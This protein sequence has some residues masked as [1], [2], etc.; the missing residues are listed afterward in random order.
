[1]P[2]LVIWR[3]QHRLA[4]TLDRQSAEHA[5]RLGAET[6]VC[7]PPAPGHAPGAAEPS[8]LWAWLGLWGAAACA[9]VPQSGGGRRVPPSPATELVAQAA[10][11]GEPAFGPL[12]STAKGLLV[13]GAVLVAF[14]ATDW[15]HEVVAL[16]AA[17]VAAQPPVSFVRRDGLCRLGAAGDVHGPVCGQP[18][19]S[20]RLA[21]EAV[22]ALAAQGIH[23]GRR[24]PLFVAGP[25]PSN[26]P[27]CARRACCC[28]PMCRAGRSRAGL[29][30]GAGH[31]A[32]GGNLL[33]V[34]SI[35]NLIVADLPPDRYRHRLKTHARIGIPVTLLTLAVVA[36]WLR[37]CERSRGLK[38]SAQK[39]RT[40]DQASRP[41][42]GI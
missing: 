22:T 14:L 4:A 30:V 11:D 6:A 28:C 38:T 15:P 19:R 23:L 5:D 16:V 3:G 36:G 13:A 20:R 42:P 17:G 12:C 1:M 41:L 27:Q 10:A 7:R 21:A 33:L 32:G 24:G 8:V 35:A 40:N 9:G 26:L 31:H 34:G 25:L 2:F 37:V 39:W 29:T 18:M